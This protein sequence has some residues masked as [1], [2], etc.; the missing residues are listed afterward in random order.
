MAGVNN[1][2]MPWLQFILR[3]DPDFQREKRRHLAYDF[4]RPGRYFY[5]D[6]QTSGVYNTYFVLDEAGN[7]IAGPDG[8][9]IVLENS[10]LG[11]RGE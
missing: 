2:D 3:A 8:G 9:R 1:V 6:P 7:R 11:N 4:P 10:P 5:E